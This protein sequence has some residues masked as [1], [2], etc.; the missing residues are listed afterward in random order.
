VLVLVT[1]DP[2]RSPRPAEAVRVAAGLAAWRKLDVVLYLH[3]AA[4]LALDSS[5]DALVDGDH[6]VQYLPVF[7]AAGGRVCAQRGAAARKGLDPTPMA[8]EPIG[9]RELAALT[10]GSYTTLRF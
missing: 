3:D 6:F 2:R 4:V 8:C 9:H 10:R 1:A 7:S 5:T